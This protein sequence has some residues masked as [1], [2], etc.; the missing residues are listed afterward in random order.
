MAFVIVSSGVL[1]SPDKLASPRR[2]SSKHT[3]LSQ[4]FLEVGSPYGPI[5]DSDIR[6]LLTQA[7]M[8]G[9]AQIYDC[10]SVSSAAC[11]CHATGNGKQ[12]PVDPLVCGNLGRGL[13]QEPA[14]M[15]GEQSNLGKHTERLSCRREV[16]SLVDAQVPPTRWRDG[17]YETSAP[18]AFPT[19]GGRLCCGRRRGA[20]VAKI[21][22]IIE[23]CLGCRAW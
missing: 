18:P 21:L 11:Q 22:N 2:A 8:C 20:S 9:R 1:S 14:G 4:R 10:F 5:M 23:A 12:D 16:S 17:G 7:R 13:V 6:T 15:A 19:R 3:C